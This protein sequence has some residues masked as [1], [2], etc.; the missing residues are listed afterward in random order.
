[1]MRYTIYSIDIEG[2]THEI[3]VIDAEK[4]NN[5]AGNGNYF[6]DEDGNLIF[7]AP[8]NS[9]KAHTEFLF[10]STYFP[11]FPTYQI[12]RIQVTLP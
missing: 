1:M 11:T 10:P 7:Y 12:F 3:A 8:A 4:L 5:V 9:L 2:K 6:Y